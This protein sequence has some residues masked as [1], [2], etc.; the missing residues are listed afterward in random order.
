MSKY[1]T[2][3]LAITNNSY[4]SLMQYK[5]RKN[6]IILEI[7]DIT[8]YV[9]DILSKSSQHSS[10]Y[11]KNHSVQEADQVKSF[12]NNPKNTQSKSMRDSLTGIP[13]WNEQ[14][15]D[16]VESNLS[17]GFIWYF[18]CNHCGQRVKYLYKYGKTKT[19]LCRLCLGIEYK[20]NI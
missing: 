7:N 18:I 2:R 3:I 4:V 8:D 19:P 1:N 16:Y 11:F 5:T 20:P 14:V 15:V 10:R 12:L 17:K 9:R 13:Y 6:W